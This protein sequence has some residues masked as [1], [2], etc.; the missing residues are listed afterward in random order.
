MGI[1]VLVEDNS[2]LEITPHQNNNGALL[3]SSFD[4]SNAANQTMVELHSTRACLVANRNSNI[5]MENVGDYQKFY[6]VGAYGSSIGEAYDFANSDYATYASAGYVQFYPNANIGHS[7]VVTSPTTVQSNNKY[8]FETDATNSPSPYYL[9]HNQSTTSDIDDISTGGMCVRAVG[10]SVVEATN[11][12][13]PATWKNASGVVYDLEGTA[14]L[15]GLNCTRLFIWN[16]A[17]TSLLKASYLTVSGSHPRD[18]GYNGPS[19]VWGHQDTVSGAP[20][21]TPDTSS[22]SVLDYYGKADD[23]PLGKST[24]ENFG[25]F[26]LY[27]SV[28]PVTNFMVA[29]GATAV[30][31]LQGIAKQVFSQGYNFSGNLVVSSSSDFTASSQYLSILQRDSNNNVVNNGFYYASAMLAGSESIKAML[32]DSALN[33]FANAKHN[34]VGKSG[35]GKVVE[36]YYNTSAFGGD[37]FNSYPYATGLASVNNFDLKKDN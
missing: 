16:I 3:V 7:D 8:V 25:A 15:P 1:D 28:D 26:R 24:A 17:D 12:H 33:T 27:F 32:D 19:G 2:T 13:F 36:G 35:L 6:S 5:F 34:M 18:A 37:S 30:N 11:V 20:M 31:Q 29:S 14:P 10:D 22:L 23:N 9:I 4:L 21:S